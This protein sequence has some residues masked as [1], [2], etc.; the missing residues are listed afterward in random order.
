MHFHGLG[1]RG[2]CLRLSPGR[3]LHGQ[4]GAQGFDII[5]EEDGTGRPDADSSGILF[6]RR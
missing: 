6:R 2:S 1:T 5:V 4:G 3:L